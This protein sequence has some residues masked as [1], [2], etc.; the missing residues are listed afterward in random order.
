MRKRSLHPEQKV[1]DVSAVNDAAMWADALVK[2]AHRG[3][4][5]TVDAAM[6]RAARKHGVPERTLWSLRYRRPKD[7]MASVYLKLHA[8]YI[9]ECERQEAILAH[10]LEVAR[11]LPTT[12]ALER[13]IAETEEHLRAQQSLTRSQEEGGA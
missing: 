10:Q 2:R 9:A 1:T 13:L 8:A 3:P 12:P 6:N 4:G 7:V 5:D 11:A